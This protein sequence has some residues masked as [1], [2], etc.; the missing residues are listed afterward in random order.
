[1]QDWV[2]SWPRSPRKD[3]EI[4]EILAFHCFAMTTIPFLNELHNTYQPIFLWCGYVGKLYKGGQ[5]F[6]ENLV[7]HPNILKEYTKEG[8]QGCFSMIWSSAGIQNW[9]RAKKDWEHSNASEA[10]R[11]LSHRSDFLVFAPV[12]PN[13]DK[14]SLC[15]T[16][17]KCFRSGSYALLF[18]FRNPWWIKWLLGDIR[19]EKKR[20]APV[21]SSGRWLRLDH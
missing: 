7:D 2:P 6:T 5:E 15:F 19:Q 18:G 12:P 20:T 4:H 3:R 13:F 8:C 16:A 21:L 10:S 17:F 9:F 14:D 11:N 1:M